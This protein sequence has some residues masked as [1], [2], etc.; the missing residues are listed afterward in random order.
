MVHLVEDLK[1]GGLERV[2][3]AV[4]TGLDKER[5]RAKAWCLTRGGEVFEELK[6]KGIEVEA[7]GMPSHRNIRFLLR[8]RAKLKDNNIHIL[9]THGYPACT[10]GRLAAISAGTPV[11]I[12]HMHSTYWD[13]SYKQILIERFLSFFTDK[14]ICCSRAVADFVVNK[15]K[16]NVKKTAVIYNG[17]DLD[18]F[19]GYLKVEEKKD[20]FVI[21]CVASLFPHKGHKYLLEAAKEVLNSF[22]GKA[23][24]VLVGRGILENSLRAYAKELSIETGVEFKGAVSDTLKLLCSF[25]L[26]VLPSSEREG[27]GLSLLEAMAA[28]KPVI[29]TAIGGISEVIREGENGLLVPAKDP[30]A[31]AKA[32]ITILQDPVMASRM[33]K[34]GRQIAEEKFSETRLLRE[35]ENLY[36]GLFSD[37]A[38]K[39]N[40]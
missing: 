25:D 6:G 4:V 15:E 19:N 34:I 37:K 16:I 39:R 40:A 14:I 31:L 20:E 26:V 22:P 12:S 9:H 11:I 35:I 17:I 7:L 2:I 24:F 21:G 29:G 38:R 23:K 3:A 32:I 33:G 10:I 27:L 18:K 5:F 13:Y 36:R 1:I 28:G 8:L 30:K